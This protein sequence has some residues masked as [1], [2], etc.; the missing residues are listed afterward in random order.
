MA[1]NAK[2][3]D[4]ITELEANLIDEIKKLADAMNGRF[5]RLKQ[6]VADY[7]NLGSDF[8][9]GSLITALKQV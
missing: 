5:E 1:D 2:E 8:A 4:V 6:V 3:G 9:K 7:L